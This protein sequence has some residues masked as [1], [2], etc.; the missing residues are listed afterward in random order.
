MLG[1]VIIDSWHLLKEGVKGVGFWKKNYCQ[2]YFEGWWSLNFLAWICNFAKWFGISFSINCGKSKIFF[3][4]KRRKFLWLRPC[5]PFWWTSSCSKAYK[6]L[7][8]WDKIRFWKIPTLCEPY[9]RNHKNS[10][11]PCLH[12][13]IISHRKFTLFTLKST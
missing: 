2:N 8:S 10:I 9:W 4:K 12:V 5:F 7:F 1:V 13:C 11:A 3:H 6:D